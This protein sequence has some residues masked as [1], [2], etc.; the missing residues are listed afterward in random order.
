LVYRKGKV[1]FSPHSYYGTETHPEYRRE[2]LEMARR[3]SADEGARKNIFFTAKEMADPRLSNC[4]YLAVAYALCAHDNGLDAPPPTDVQIRR[5]ILDYMPFP[6]EKVREETLKSWPSVP[7]EVSMMEAGACETMFNEERAKR[8]LRQLGLHVLYEN[9]KG[10]IFPLRASTLFQREAAKLVEAEEENR[11]T[12]LT[13]PNEAT[14][15]PIPVVLLFSFF[16]C[17]EPDKKRERKVRGHFALIENVDKLLSARAKDQEGVVTGT[18]RCGRYCMNCFLFLF[19]ESTYRRHVVWCYERSGQALKLPKPDTRVRFENAHKVEYLLPF[20]CV[21]DFES[22]ARPLTREKDGN[23]GC[24]CSWEAVK[25]ADRYATDPKVREE[26]AMFIRDGAWNALT[27]P[28]RCPHKTRAISQQ[29]PFAVSAVVVDRFGKLCEEFTYAGEDCVPVFLHKVLS[30][31]AAYLDRVSS[32]NATP[33]RMDEQT[34]DELTFKV[35]T[36]QAD[37]CHICK[38]ENVPL[39]M[40]DFVFDHGEQ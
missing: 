20:F 19:R 24:V 26:A 5:Y 31:E 6:S 9:D 27:A 38:D 14:T 8:G 18:R 40:D 12:D 16:E 17:V 10:D 22:F 25:E 33:M 28:R 13:N 4:F 32:K 11:D 1:E 15:M 39:T 30:W 2:M 23:V 35:F 37:A 34:K 29:E 36:G 3:E 21:F 7:M